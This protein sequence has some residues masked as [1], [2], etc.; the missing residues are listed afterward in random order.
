M[1]KPAQITAVKGFRDI[2][3][4]E[5]AR[6][7]LLET[8]AF[9][10]FARYSF[11]EIRLPM[12]EKTELFARSIGAATDIVE[13]EMYTFTDRGGTSITLR[14]EATASVVRAAI[15]H[16]LVGQE[17]ERRFFYCG[18]MF[19]R[20]R[21]QKGRFRQFYQIGA[22]VLG[23]DDPVVDAEVIV[24]LRDLLER[25]GAGGAKFEINS[26]GD[27]R[28]RPAYREQLHGFAAERRE[29]LCRNCQQ[30]LERN[31]LRILDCKEEQ[32]RKEL[33]TAP[34]MVDH[35]CQPCADHLASVQRLLDASGVSVEVNPR[36]VR[37]L[38][39]YCRTAFEITAE[40]LGSQN[41]VGGGGR[42][43][44]LVA[45]LGGPPVAG[46]GFAIGVERLAMVTEG[47]SA[48]A[49]GPE[50][51]I[52]PLG[53]EALTRGLVVATGL[54]G[55]GSRVEL[56]S[57]GKSLR[58]LMRRADRAGARH[59]L[60]IGADELSSGRGTV[61]DMERKTDHPLSVDLGAAG[62]ELAAQIARLGDVAT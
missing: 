43:D 26:L 31:T 23:R 25:V 19:R 36:I 9:E 16:G 52:A 46:I 17:R 61:R 37:G 57:G 27:G 48:S 45:A 10:V 49:G 51:F 55:A 7:R 22:E 58:T 4:D 34:L 41:A 35:L 1:V 29:R 13:K 54:R 3:P 20:E 40:G 6:W 2:L 50:V 8:E 15:E 12:A 53:E 44:D 60:I 5:S 47:I 39:Y 14:P 28:C 38:D 42:Y 11:E 30:R 18:P 62:A 33:V 21:P 56:A 24:L 32:C 59:V